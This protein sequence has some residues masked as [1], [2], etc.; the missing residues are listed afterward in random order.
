M[1][2]YFLWAFCCVY[3]LINTEFSKANAKE[4]NLHL[5]I[6]TFY[7]KEFNLD[8]M[9]GKVVVVNFWAQWCSNCAREMKVLESLYQQYH[10]QGLEIIGVSVD[11][12]NDI[13]LVLERAKKLTYPNA[14]FSNTTV[15]N[16][17]DIHSIPANFIF[18]K[19]GNLISTENFD[20]EDNLSFD[21]LE[22]V[23]KSLL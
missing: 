13:K 18:D 2:K 23:I 21:T 6:K 16:F 15:S 11:G 1:K 20:N 8:K 12:K 10:G 14:M 4:E 19:N 7:D 17:P 5:V 22:K 3:L 9:R